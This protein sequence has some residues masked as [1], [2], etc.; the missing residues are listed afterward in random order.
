MTATRPPV[1]SLEAFMVARKPKAH[2]ASPSSGASAIG[3][4]CGA[5]VVMI[6][7]FPVRLTAG[8][9]SSS[10]WAFDEPTWTP[11]IVQTW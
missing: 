7:S 10:L 11:R 1:V 8:G 4:N 9:N 5:L 3:A 6:A 2:S